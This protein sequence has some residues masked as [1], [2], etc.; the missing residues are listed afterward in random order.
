MAIDGVRDSLGLGKGFNPVGGKVIGDEKVVDKPLHQVY[1]LGDGHI[2]CNNSGGN[3][4]IGDFIVASA[5]AGI[6]MK[7]DASGMAC[8]IA[9]E[10]ISF[11]SSSETKLVAVEFGLRQYIHS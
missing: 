2:L 6:G 9:R 7:A 1:I 5:T 11:S 3:I 4:S 8:G 10:N